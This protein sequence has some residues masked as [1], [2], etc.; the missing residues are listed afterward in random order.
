MLGIVGAFI[1]PLLLG[2]DLPDPRL[3]LAYILVIDLGVLAV[4]TFRNWRW[5]TL[6]GLAGS[7]GLFALW[8]D[9]FPAQSAL[10]VH[11]FLSGVFL[12]FVGATSLFHILWRRA[13]GPVDL[14][15]IT[16]NAAGYYA[17]TFGLLWAEYRIWFGGITLSLSL[18]YGLVA[19]A[20]IK[21]SGAPPEVALFALA[22]AVV[23]L[24]I[25]VPL[26]LSGNWVS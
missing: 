17:L 2:R 22:T 15:L 19:Y 20:A 24:T 1:T 6:V 16:L 23:F 26:Q 25:A 7:Y 14:V 3:V 8:L 4:A 5:F 9:Q 12:V 11:L 13:P 18:L 10:L 21:R